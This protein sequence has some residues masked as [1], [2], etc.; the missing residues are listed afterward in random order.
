M[1][2]N[3]SNEQ[4]RNDNFTKK[5]RTKICF[6]KPSDTSSWLPKEV[7][8]HGYSQESLVKNKSYTDVVWLLI[9]GELPNKEQ[10]INFERLFT[11]LSCP[12]PR[13]PHS[14]AVM[15]ASIGK[16]HFEHW[17]PIG[18]NVASGSYGGSIEVFEAMRFIQKHIKDK[19]SPKEIA[20]SKIASPVN[21]HPGEYSLAPGF[22]TSY[23]DIDTHLTE[24]IDI[25]SSLF[26]TP[27]MQWSQCFVQEI[28]P[29][30]GWRLAGIVAAVLS[31]LGFSSIQASGIFQMA[32]MPGLLAYAD[33]KSGKPL[34]EMPFLDESQYDIKMPSGEI[35]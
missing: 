25:F 21:E 10:A 8:W 35:K 13:A 26:Q 22:G 20:N 17:L 32:I 5:I 23:G 4:S 1:A 12:S 11:L 3:T 31:A 6:E 30:G 34:T 15:N 28:A 27:E 9:R 7:Y 14:R 16:T 2:S 33:E 19:K 18:L 24:L 29:Q